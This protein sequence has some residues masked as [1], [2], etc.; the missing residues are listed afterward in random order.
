MAYIRAIQKY[1][2][3]G[4]SIVYVDKTYL[5]SSHTTPNEWTDGS[6]G[7]VKAPMNKGQRLIIIHAGDI[8]FKCATQ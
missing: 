3:E 7:G 5:H 2:Q 4:R 8:K 6:A 1:Q